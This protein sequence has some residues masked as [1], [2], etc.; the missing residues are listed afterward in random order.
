M[1]RSPIK[2]AVDPV[3]SKNPYDRKCL[4]GKASHFKA[5]VVKYRERNHQGLGNRLINRGEEVGVTEGSIAY[6]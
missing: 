6:R 3:V 1:C 2:R 5:R 4:S